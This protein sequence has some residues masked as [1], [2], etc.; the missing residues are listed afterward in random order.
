MASRATTLEAGP[1]PG[2]TAPQGQQ[3]SAAAQ[4]PVVA[5]PALRPVECRNPQGWAAQRICAD[6]QLRRMDEA[7]TRHVG[8][9]RQR[10]AGQP[11]QLRE[12]EAA[13]AA[14]LRQRQDCARPIGR[15]PEDCILETLEDAEHDWGRMA[16][17]VTPGQQPPRR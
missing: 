7:I 5:G 14:H 1:Q 11:A 2:M 4:P 16:T 3:S 12:F 8:T 13:V 9:V 15:V 6:P 10:L 17:P